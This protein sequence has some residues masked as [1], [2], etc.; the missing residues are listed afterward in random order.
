M[1]GGIFTA[2]A[3]TFTDV[4]TSIG[5]AISALWTMFGSLS[6][7]V[8]SNMIIFVPIVLALMLSLVGVALIIMRK[9]GI[10]GLN[11]GG[12]RRRGRR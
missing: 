5:T 10:R 2:L 4:L 1:K 3:I 8:T 12:R 9:L 7:I 11:G 6:D